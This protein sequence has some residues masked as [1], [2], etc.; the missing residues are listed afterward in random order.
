MLKY[1]LEIEV[2]RNKQGI[3]LYQKKYAL[4]FL[5]KT[6][7]L[8]AKLCSTPMNHAMQ[9]TNDGELF[10]D[11]EKYCRLVRKLN[12]LIVTRYCILN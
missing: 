9:L 12:Y 8:G 2:T 11:P 7:K 1:F 6:E 5:T 4:D 3:F 10:E